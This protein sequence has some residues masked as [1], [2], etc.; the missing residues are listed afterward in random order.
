MKKI[1]FMSALLI[2]LVAAHKNSAEEIV[3]DHFDQKSSEEKNDEK[4]KTFQAG[5]AAEITEKAIKIIQEARK[6]EEAKRVEECDQLKKKLID[7]LVTK[8]VGQPLLFDLGGARAFD[9][10]VSSKDRF[11]KLKCYELYGK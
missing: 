8:L 1:I 6:K 11:Y 3:S 7:Y 10:Y 2:S 9:D 4:M 5:C